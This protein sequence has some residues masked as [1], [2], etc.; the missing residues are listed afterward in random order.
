[1]HR[2]NPSRL[3]ERPMMLFRAGILVLV[4]ALFATRSHAGAVPDPVLAFHEGF[5]NPPFFYE[6]LQY[7]G[8]GGCNS[9]FNLSSSPSH[10]GTSAAHAVDPNTAGERWLQ[11]ATRIS[12]PGNAE[13]AELTFW[14]R[15]DFERSGEFTYDGGVLEVST[16]GSA[17]ENSNWNDVGPLMTA[18][19]YTGTILTGGQMNPLAGR[20]GW[21]GANGDWQQ[22]R[23][24]LSS[25]R[26]Q[27][28][29]FRFGL[30]TDIS[31]NGT[32]DGW[33]LDDIELSYRAPLASCSRGWAAVSPYPLAA[34]DMALVGVG[35]AV[36]SFGG[37]LQD[38]SATAAAYR[39]SAD[40]DR[41]TP[42]APL[43]EPR[44]GAAAV[45]DGTYIYVLG[46]SSDSDTAGTTSL[47]RYD[48]AT[49]G[50]L[51]LKPF[52]IATV[53]HAAVY[54]NGII[55]RIAGSRQYNVMPA[56]ASVE[57][58]T[59]A[60]NTWQSVA[61]YPDTQQRFAAMAFDGY[62][63][64][65]GG[66]GPTSAKAYRYDPA[67]NVWDVGPI[68]DLPGTGGYAFGALFNGTWIVFD[69][70]SWGLGWDPT[71]NYWRSLDFIPG[72]VFG[73]Q[74]AATNT[75]AYA[76]D[77]SSNPA[78][79]TPVW[80]YGETNCAAACL[81]DCGGDGAVAVSD[82]VR[83]VA[84]ALNQ[85]PLVACPSFDGN[86]DGRV[87]VNELVTA[88]GNALGGCGRS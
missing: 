12:I 5:E 38:H 18:G 41:W 26:G 37:D 86:H 75:A 47:W 50:Y 34:F 36:Y 43:P 78:V 42:I 46:G 4:S 30:G 1:V 29:D 60:S 2:E 52:T 58:Y 70:N 84:I 77:S 40:D 62:I 24:D 3:S 56:L 31:T 14:H 35:E 19:G 8:D 7:C 88:V 27:Y 53:S 74:V 6:L 10:T 71:T 44:K 81:G 55:Y 82:L 66:G 23:V 54:L 20:A 69:I 32:F 63:Y 33:R 11:L 65:A 48:P 68:A 22:V 15:F 59:V 72:G 67:R 16:Q 9:G 57:A 64:T 49:N 25:Y 45:T 83:G 39:Y 79:A 17:P 76:F 21:V 87:S 61:D 73:A 28:I 13:S 51:M 85:Q 80:Q